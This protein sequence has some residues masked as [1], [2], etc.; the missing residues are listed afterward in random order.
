MFRTFHA[1]SL[2]KKTNICTTNTWHQPYKRKQIS[3][4]RMSS[5]F[6]SWC[7]MHF[8]EKGT[9]YITSIWYPSHGGGDVSGVSFL[10]ISG[11]FRQFPQE[12]NF[13]ATE[14]QHYFNGMGGF[15]KVAQ[16]KASQNSL[17]ELHE[18]HWNFAKLPDTLWSPCK[19]SSL[20]S[21]LWWRPS[22][23]SPLKRPCNAPNM[24]A[25]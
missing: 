3:I 17:I 22:W 18:T 5:L 23:W 6:I 19:E 1:V 11:Y 13:Y 14:H 8:P 15:C 25:S 10:C 16:R 2:K 24:E 21:F 9:F 7:V 12:I 20:R 4:C